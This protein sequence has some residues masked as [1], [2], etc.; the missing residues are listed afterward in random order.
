MSY[1]EPPD[2][3]D[4]D[5][6]L[7][8]QQGDERRP[9]NALYPE[10]STL[11]Q[12]A[13]KLLIDAGVRYYGE[14]PSAIRRALPFLEAQELTI[15]K[16]LTSKEP[17]K[18]VHGYARA[19]A[20]MPTL[21]IVLSTENSASEERLF[22]DYATIG[23]DNY[24]DAGWGAAEIYSQGFDANFRLIVYAEN[25]DVTIY[26]YEMVMYILIQARLLLSKLGIDVPTMSG[27]DLQ[28]LPKS[29]AELLYLR[30]IR[31]RCRT[32]RVFA[33]EAALVDHLLVKLKEQ[34][35]TFG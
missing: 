9:E 16:Q 34:G 6:L 28:T 22:G 1:E 23:P 20:V 33:Q 3:L 29:E 31:F 19:N 15:V 26:W 17:L 4:G 32:R 18:T 2:F 14:N 11:V 25:P 21:A 30:E 12:R 24:G 7:P 13:L 35:I 10:S 27:G 5:E 8:E